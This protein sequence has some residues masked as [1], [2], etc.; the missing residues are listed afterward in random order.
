[1]NHLSSA[2]G[3]GI[4]ID[5]LIACWNRLEGLKQPAPSPLLPELRFIVISYVGLVLTIPSLFPQ[6]VSAQEA[7]PGILIPRLQSD[8]KLIRELIDRY[9]TE[10]Q[11]EQE[12][13]EEKEKEK[14]TATATA[15]E[16]EKACRKR[17]DRPMDPL[18]FPSPPS[19]LREV[20]EPILMELSQTCVQEGILGRNL[21]PTLDTIQ[22][23]LQLHPAM[24]S[25]LLGSPLW[26]GPYTAP[27]ICHATLLGSFLGLGV[28]P[29]Y[30]KPLRELL[31]HMVTAM[32][33]DVPEDDPSSSVSNAQVASAMYALRTAL[34]LL[35]S[36][37]HGL[38]LFIIKSSPMAKEAV[39]SWWAWL[40]SINGERLKMHVREE[41][42]SD[43][44][45]L[46]NMFMVLLR[47]C[48]PF[49]RAPE[50]LTLINPAY[51]WHV[52]SRIDVMEATKNHATAAEYKE[53]VTKYREQHE[54]EYGCSERGKLG[55]GT[56]Y[57]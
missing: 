35:V 7:G 16:R 19:M 24:I 57:S 38:L 43:D 20:F 54:R 47:F 10:E 14:V 25:V 21:L 48:G 50:K 13:E 11:E 45:L 55:T 30:T 5:Y 37:L 15:P 56:V 23:L 27:M 51:Y 6:P 3:T 34:E 22:A 2:P 31:P 52:T 4:V 17:E 49:L 26:R 32:E 41:T 53:F 28:D 46:A 40:A 42:V 29:H 36:R 39:L 12:E 9:A 8:S 18:T 44:R 33:G 1:M